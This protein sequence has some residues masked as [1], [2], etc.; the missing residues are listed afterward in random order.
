MAKARD[1]DPAIELHDTAGTSQ[2]MMTARDTAAVDGDQQHTIRRASTSSSSSR[3]VPDNAGH[4]EAT[5]NQSTPSQPLMASDYATRDENQQKV[6]T[7]ASTVS[8][9][10]SS[11]HR[12]DCGEG[13]LPPKPLMPLTNA[14]LSL[15]VVELLTVLALVITGLKMLTV[16]P[17]LDIFSVP[18]MSQDCGGYSVPSVERRLYIN[19]QVVRGLSFA[20]AKLLDLAWDTIIGQGGKFLHGW[21]FY[22]V[23]ASQLTWMMEYSSVPYHFQLDL[24]FSTVSLSALWSTLRFM[25]VKRPARAVFFAVWVLLAVSYILAFSS[26][27]SAATGYLN[28][29]TPAYRMAD[30][31]YATVQSDSLRLCWVV[32]TERLNGVVP[33]VVPGPRLGDCVKSFADLGYCDCNLRNGSD[34]WRNLIACEYNQKRSP[35]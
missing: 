31:S 10:A 34:D 4:S 35:V 11:S 20:R 13:Y 1:M 15:L 14:Q 16:L 5:D 18:P 2:P 6:A 21:V 28:P 23:V 12:T 30:Q 3:E 32:D 25:S 8:D 24:L 26:I 17:N 33:A 29:S 19:A 22:R 7:A 27:W 9:D